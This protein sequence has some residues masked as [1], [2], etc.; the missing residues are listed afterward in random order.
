MYAGF[1][2]IVFRLLT[3]TI[4]YKNHATATVSV[5][6]NKTIDEWHS[7][8][9]ACVHAKGRHFEHLLCLT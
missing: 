7:R 3:V 9:A 4:Y 6:S 2:I 1:I 5:Y 8:L